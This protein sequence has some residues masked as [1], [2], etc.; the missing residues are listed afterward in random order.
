MWLGRFM[1]QA[2]LGAQIFRAAAPLRVP[3]M[4]DHD[5]GAIELPYEVECVPIV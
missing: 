4:H 3:F 5:I 2:S 1:S